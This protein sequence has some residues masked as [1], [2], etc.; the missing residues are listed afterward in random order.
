VDPLGRQQ[1]R[2]RLEVRTWEVGAV[3]T[4]DV[5]PLY[6]RLGDWVGWA[7]LVGTG[8]FVAFAL[9]RRG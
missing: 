5:A 2:T 7:S 9:R 4:A 8:L 6:T 1:Q 3:T